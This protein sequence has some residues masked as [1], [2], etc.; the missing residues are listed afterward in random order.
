MSYR[1]GEEVMPKQIKCPNCKKGITVPEWIS[2]KTYDGQIRCW[3]GCQL[4]WNIVICQNTLIS[5]RLPYLNNADG[6]FN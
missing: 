6:R 5:I 2:L 3:Q 1:P 4:L